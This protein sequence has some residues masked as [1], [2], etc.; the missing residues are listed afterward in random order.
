MSRMGQINFTFDARWHDVDGFS[1]WRNIET[2][3]KFQRLITTV[4]RSL[5]LYKNIIWAPLLLLLVLYVCKIKCA[6]VAD[7]YYNIIIRF[8][9]AR[10]RVQKV[11]KSVDTVS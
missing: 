5:L 11:D 10:T 8:D 7:H 4:P 1:F 3:W 9:F 6:L 2:G